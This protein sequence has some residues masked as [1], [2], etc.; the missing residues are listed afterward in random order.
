MPEFAYQTPFR[1]APTRP[2]TAVSAGIRLDRDV[3]GRGD[4]QGR[5]PRRC[6]LLAR[7]AFRDVS[8]LYRA[9]APGEGRG[10]PRRSRGL[11]QRPRRRADPAQERRR[12]L[13]LPAA[14]VPGHRHRHDRRQ[15]RPARL[16]RRARTRSGSPGGSTRPTQKENL[17][18]SQTVPL[19][20]Y[21]EIN[22]GTNLP[23]QIDIY[24]DQRRDV[25]VPVRRQGG[26]VGQQVDALPGDQGAAQSGEPGEVPRPEAA[27]ARHG[28]VPALSPGGRDRRHLG[29]GDDEDGEARQHGLPRSRCR[30]RATSSARRSATPSWRRR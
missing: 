26:R 1:S 28:R 12:R 24:A 6:T 17:R 18:Y 4:P 30:P 22:S 14:D 10:D 20:M 16:D 11:A 8:F 25:R 13:G 7:E 21:E 3:R 23:A 2:N 15:E 5:S 27:L 9:V 19:S 29:R